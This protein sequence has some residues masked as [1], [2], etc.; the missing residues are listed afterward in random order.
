MSKSTTAKAEENSDIPKIELPVYGFVSELPPDLLEGKTKAQIW[1]MEKS[2]KVD[3]FIEW[4]GPILVD[5]NK[6][7]RITNG[8]VNMHD[9]QIEKNT[10]TLVDLEIHSKDAKDVIESAKVIFRVIK[11]KYFWGGVAIFFVFVLPWI[12]KHAPTADELVKKLFGA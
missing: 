12:T 11:N 10:K 4:A 1:Q 7:Q 2:M 6:H 8:R 9:E 3:N 5:I